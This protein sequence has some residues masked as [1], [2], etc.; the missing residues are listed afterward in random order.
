MEALWDGAELRPRRVVRGF[1]RL[2]AEALVQLLRTTE[3]A[4]HPERLELGSSGVEERA[5]APGVA[6][7][8]SAATHQGLVV[9]GDPPQ[10]PGALLVEDA[11]GFGEPGDGLVEAAGEGAQA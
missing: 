6:G 3:P 5:G 8:S 9:V 4:G 10:R 1:D 11:P 7:S 2:G